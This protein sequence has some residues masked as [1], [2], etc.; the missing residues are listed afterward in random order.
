MAVITQNGAHQSGLL[1]H[2]LLDSHL[3]FTA[4][5]RRATSHGTCIAARRPSLTRSPHVACAEGS[6]SQ[7]NDPL[8]KSSKSVLRSDGAVQQHASKSP[9]CAGLFLPPPHGTCIRAWRPFFTRRPHV[10]P[11]GRKP[12]T[13]SSF[14]TGRSHCRRFLACH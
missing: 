5:Y 3:H 7:R 9:S 12:A 8:A 13:T 1:L 14:C 11:A 6:S 2:P 10:S 4:L